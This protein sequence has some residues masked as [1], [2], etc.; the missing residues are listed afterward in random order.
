MSVKYITFGVGEGCKLEDM[1]QQKHKSLI[2][3]ELISRV[4]IIYFP[5]FC[6][7]IFNRNRK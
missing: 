3:N 4:G 6:K 1:L 2:I 7:D 5:L